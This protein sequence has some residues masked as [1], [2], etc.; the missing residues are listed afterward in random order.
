MS[1]NSATLNSLFAVFSI[2]LPLSV[3]A[4]SVFRYPIGVL[5][6]LF[7]ALVLLGI[8]LLAADTFKKEYSPAFD[9]SYSRPLGIFATLTALAMLAEFVA[10]VARLYAEIAARGLRVF[11]LLGVLEAVSAFLSALY[12]SFVSLTFRGRRYDFQRLFLL[13]L[14]PVLW[15]MLKTLGL[16]EQSR[17]VKSDVNGILGHLVMVLLLCFFYCFAQEVHSLKGAKPVTVFFARA[18]AYCAMLYVFDELMQLL[19]GNNGIFSESPLF[20]VTA[21]VLCGFSF[22]FEKNIYLKSE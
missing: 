8:L 3:R 13:H 17:D 5:S 12:F 4:V 21:A 15:A 19:A 11:T 1:R 16:M 10:A 9:G 6:Y 14:A 20:A 7:Y 18:V 22:T 2:L